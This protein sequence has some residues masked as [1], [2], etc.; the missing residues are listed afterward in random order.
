[1]NELTWLKDILPGK[2]FVTVARLK[3]KE[4]K[5][6][7]VNDPYL[8]LVFED[9]TGTL[10]STLWNPDASNLQETLRQG[11]AFRIEGIGTSYRGKRCLTIKALSKVSHEPW[12]QE[13]LD[14]L[15]LGQKQWLMA[16]LKDLILKVEHPF[17]RKLLLSFLEDQAFMERFSETPGGKEIHHAYQGGLLE[18]TVSIMGMCCKVKEHY[19]SLNLDFLLTGAFLHDIGKVEELD[20]NHEGVYT[21]EGRLLGHITLGVLMTEKRIS[22]IRGFPASLRSLVL[23]LILSHQGSYEFGSPRRPKFAEALALYYLD[24]LDS[25]LYHLKDFIK[26]QSH[27]DED[28]PWTDYNRWLDRYLLKDPANLRSEP[29]LEEGFTPPSR[30]P[31][32]TPSL[33][34]KMG[35]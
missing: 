20:R 27:D 24:E 8:K 11:D 22:K 26:Q 32:L 31:R 16:R 33:F 25:K 28:E 30:G 9:Q 2:T 1:M 34:Q 6:S 14:T 19:H 23:H 18:H 29:A 10:E 7:K 21:D 4:R 12:V 35:G 13:R 17:L 3:I 5:V 15:P